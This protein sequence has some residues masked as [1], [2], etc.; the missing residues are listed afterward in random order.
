MKLALTGNPV[1]DEYLPIVPLPKFDTYRVLPFTKTP[2]G[3]FSPVIKLPLSPRP[4]LALNVLTLLAG[5]SSVTYSACAWTF[6]GRDQ[7]MPTAITDAYK[8]AKSGLPFD[9]VLVFIWMGSRE[10]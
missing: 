3:V 1:M 7:S 9:I 2:L 8:A 6:L 4:V 5:A 10:S